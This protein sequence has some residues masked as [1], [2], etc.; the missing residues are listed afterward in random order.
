MM[1]SGLMWAGLFGILNGIKSSTDVKVLGLEE[2]SQPTTFISKTHRQ[3]ECKRL[4]QAGISLC[5]CWGGEVNSDI[6]YCNQSD[7]WLKVVLPWGR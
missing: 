5:V 1:S 6:I 2:T 3:H 7:Q 4:H